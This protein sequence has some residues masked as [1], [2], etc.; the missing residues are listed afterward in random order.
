MTEFQN[1]IS[2]VTSTE[3]A[4]ELL[5]S[6]FVHA[7]ALEDIKN[8]ID[9]EDCCAVIVRYDTG[10]GASTLLRQ[11]GKKTS[12]ARTILTVHGTPSLGSVSY[13]ALAPYLRHLEHDDVG[14]RTNVLRAV[15]AELAATRPGEQKKAQTP[16]ILVDD[17]H[18][19]DPSTAEMLLTLVLSGTAKLV[20]THRRNE[21]LPDPLKQLWRAGNAESVELFPLTRDEC[22]N[23]CRS[24]LTAPIAPAASW[25]FW[26]RSEG[27]PLLLRMLVSEALKEGW[28]FK[29][30][31]VWHYTEGQY[32]VG[33]DLRLA[34]LR[35]IRGLSV[36]AK[37]ALDIVA[38]AGPVA[39]SIVEYVCG[40]D[41]VQELLTRQLIGHLVPEDGLLR[42]SSP[43]YGEA[44][45]QLVPPAQRRI[46]HDSLL[47]KLQAEPTVAEAL[48]RRI[49]W[50]VDAGVPVS[51]QQL[52]NAALT[53]CKV[54]QPN[55][56]L[57]L[58][59]QVPEQDFSFRTRAIM[60]RAYYLLGN[61]EKAAQLLDEGFEEASLEDLLLGALLRTTTKMAVGYPVSALEEDL[62][63]FKMAGQHLA[64]RLPEES[65]AIL[66]QVALKEK[67][68]Q[69]LVLSRTGRYNIM[70]PLIESVLAESPLVSAQDHR[71]NA[72]FALTM[73]AE[74]LCVLGLAS[75][76]QER[77]AQAMALEQAEQHDIFF[78][79][80]T[81]IFRQ[82]ATGLC[83]GD[84]ELVAKLMDQFIVDV[85]AIS[86]TFGGW[87]DVARGM[88]L[89]REGMTAEALAVLLPSLDA[90]RVSDPQQLLDFCTSMTAF[91]AAKLGRLDIARNLINEHEE[92]PAIFLV[93]AHARAFLAAA[94][95]YVYRD[96]EGLVALVAMAVS[97]R[98][99]GLP[100]LELNALV[101]AVELGESTVLDRLLELAPSIEGAW[102]EGV[103]HMGQE[104]AANRIPNEPR[105][106]SSRT[107]HPL[108]FTRPGNRSVH[109]AVNSWNGL[110]NGSEPVLIPDSTIITYTAPV[111]LTRRER[112]IA[113]LAV[114][115]LSDK[116]IATKLS[117][118]TR[119]VE[120]HLYRTYA[121]LGI[122]GRDDLTADLLG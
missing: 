24:M 23:Y 94:K 118:S 15:M 83:S 1:H 40:K 6:P 41:A 28:L 71:L 31:D 50:A 112:E 111:H 3:S 100:L 78:I 80:E 38:L 52:V 64:A 30:Q 56:A 21:S 101:L 58:L 122:A 60:A 120:G 117:L 67:L 49:S 77:A 79:P 87:P 104:L 85:G 48:V 35:Q 57:E 70:E 93:T 108:W 47:E 14:L 121:K 18:A 39:P 45:R 10:L 4:Y 105:G 81:I 33:P 12:A 89:L 86:V 114:Q 66:G 82:L 99:E 29:K 88:G 84:L 96:G 102:A 69:L 7:A 63:K 5:P 61:S 98:R 53:A 91:A 113:T 106:I 20:A 103:T 76:S 59:G 36:V 115:G 42:L 19:V 75:Q 34:V 97:Y 62:E 65:A 25:H 11:L 54:M 46:L 110:A 107:S 26:V 37:E 32:P 73:D 92:R 27:N 90:L 55:S 44:I 51:S 43:I 2:P 95:E 72:A 116:A 9:D 22:D 68:L 17:A 8:A 13:G 74:R 119:T 16:L 109:T